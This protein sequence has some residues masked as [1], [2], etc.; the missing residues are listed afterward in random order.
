MAFEEEFDVEIPDDAAETI[1]TVGDAV[2]SSRRTPP[3]GPA[4]R[5]ASRRPARCYRSIGQERHAP[6]RCHGSRHG[7]AAGLRG[8]A[9][10]V[11]PLAGK[12]GAD[13]D[14]RASRSTISPARSPARSPAATAPTAPSIP[15]SGWSRRSSARSIHFIVYAMAAA[16]QALDDAGWHP[17]TYEDQMRHRRADRLRHRRHRRHLRG[18]RHPDRARPAPHL[19]LL[20][21]R[22]PDQPRRRLRLDRAR[23]QGPEPRGGHRLLDRRPTRSA[24]PRG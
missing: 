23:P 3:E 12:S 16:D 19:A 22:P 8:R 13:A 18:L 7:H 4:R 15:T 11:E 20:H 2:A 6:R 24:T 9:D 1:V 17:T 21:S 14:R 10:L 5:R